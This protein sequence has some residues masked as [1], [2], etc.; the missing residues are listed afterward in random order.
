MPKKSKAEQWLAV[1]TRYERWVRDKANW[2]NLFEPIWPRRQGEPPHPGEL[3]VDRGR[4]KT[5][6]EKRLSDLHE[7][8]AFVKGH[9]PDMTNN[10]VF[11]LLAK[12][13]SYRGMN[14]TANALQKQWRRGKRI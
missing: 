5:W 1:A 10:E 7:D 13:R 9:R 4:P 8:Y 14:I 11:E 3:P 2:P 12:S 6:D